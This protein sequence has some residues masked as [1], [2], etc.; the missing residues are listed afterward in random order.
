ML[1]ISIV[2][3]VLFVIFGKSITFF[4]GKLC[5]YMSVWFSWKINNFKQNYM[6]FQMCLLLLADLKNFSIGRSMLVGQPPMKSLSS[7][8]PSVCPSVHLSLDLSF[9]LKCKEPAHDK[10]T[11]DS[12]DT[13]LHKAHTGIAH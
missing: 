12:V 7:V 5:C 8:S 6:Q 1:S 11:L 2:F 9:L 3:R 13:L 10:G 4:N